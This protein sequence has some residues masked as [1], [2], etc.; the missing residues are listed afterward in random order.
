MKRFLGLRGNSLNIAAILGVALPG[1][2]TV[3]YNQTLL[4]GVLMFSSFQHQFRAIDVADADDADKDYTSTIQGTVVALYAVG[5][6]MGALSCIWLGDRLGRRRIIMASSAVQIV[7]S[8][9]MAIASGLPLL[10]VSRL[11]L[12]VGT[13]GLVATIPVYQSEI[14]PT[15]KRGAHVATTGV[16]IGLGLT[17][18]LWV[19]FGMSFVDGTIAW[20]FPFALQALF[21]LIV[22]GFMGLLPESPR[23]LI[24][25]GCIAEAR[26]I[27]AALDDTTEDN[28]G[29]Q[30]EIDDVKLSLQLA[31]KS[32]SGQM[33]HMGPQRIFHRIALAA[34]IMMFLQLTG[35]NAITLYSTWTR[36]L[37]LQVL[38]LTAL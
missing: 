24:K 17:T 5:G 11:V 6:L 2:I 22:I 33:F 15:S 29:I 37:L 13:G 18:A 21:S 34:T 16:F 12:G 4:G 30:A 32:S 38:L 20:R 27:L 25:Q 10:T 1:L 14:S 26:E 19:D 23:W 7:G 36:A 28:Q 31:G 9:L 8:V 3:G 35:V